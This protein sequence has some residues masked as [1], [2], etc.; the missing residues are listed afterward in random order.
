MIIVFINSIWWCL[1]FKLGTIKLNFLITFVH[2]T[3]ASSV[4]PGSSVIIMSRNLKYLYKKWLVLVTIVGKHLLHFKFLEGFFEFLLRNDFNKTTEIFITVYL[5]FSKKKKI[6]KNIQKLF[7]FLFCILEFLSS[8]L[9]NWSFSIS[10]SSLICAF[11][12]YSFLL[13]L[14]NDS[15]LEFVSAGSNKTIEN[16]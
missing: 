15:L 8:Q 6:N 4:S 3:V 5:W 14:L 1:Y 10:L 11:H 2:W 9:I 7:S 16:V 12:L 13:M